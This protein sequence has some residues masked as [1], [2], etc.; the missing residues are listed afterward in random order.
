MN[1]E[2][3]KG[4]TIAT[5]ENLPLGKVILKRKMKKQATQGLK[6]PI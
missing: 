5:K 3:D 2:G 1:T 4:E 6:Q